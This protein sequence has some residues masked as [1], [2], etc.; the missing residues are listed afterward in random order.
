VVSRRL[1]VHGVRFCLLGGRCT[2]RAA[3]HQAGSRGLDLGCSLSVAAKDHSVLVPWSAA[4]ATASEGMGGCRVFY[5][6]DHT[7][8]GPLPVPPVFRLYR[9][10]SM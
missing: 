2:H 5:Q 4:A 8:R 6:V 7:N 3:S 10:N 9:K 1:L